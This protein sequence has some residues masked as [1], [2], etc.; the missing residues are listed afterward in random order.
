MAK[1]FEMVPCMSLSLPHVCVC[2]C[3]I[4]CVCVFWPTGRW[5]KV[6]QLLW[7]PEVHL[8]CLKLKVARRG[9]K[10]CVAVTFKQALTVTHFVLCVHIGM[11]SSQVKHSDPELSYYRNDDFTKT[12]SMLSLCSFITRKLL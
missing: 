10:S 1:K 2:V 9:D 6:S 5:G 4:L 8:L 11:G 12:L 3:L 7:I